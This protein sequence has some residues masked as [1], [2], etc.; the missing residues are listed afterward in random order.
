VIDEFARMGRL[1]VEG[2]AIE[3]RWRDTDARQL[4]PEDYLELIWRKTCWY[5]TICPLRVGAIIGTRDRA[6]LRQLNRLGFHLGVAFQI[7]DD[8][9]N[10]VDWNERFG[11][12]RLDDLREGKRTLM[13]IHLAGTVEGAD[14]AF[15][16]SF[17]RLA[18]DDRDGD[19]LERLLDL[20]VARGSIQFAEEYARGIA[21]AALVAYD[22]AFARAVPGDA[23]RFV[24]GLVPYMLDRRH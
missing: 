22:A 1:T 11:K 15:V 10:L 20:M 8:L 23:S 4:T 16:E 2:Q 24:R 12:D 3:L 5:T 6:P 9:L 18:P 7:R 14:A 13:L 21:S 19:M 17:L